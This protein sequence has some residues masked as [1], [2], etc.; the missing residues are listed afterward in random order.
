MII[1]IIKISIIDAIYKDN[2]D[3]CDKYRKVMNE[4]HATVMKIQN[5]LL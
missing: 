1:M 3:P 2:K 4:L 5:M